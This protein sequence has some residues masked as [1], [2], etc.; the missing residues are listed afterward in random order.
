LSWLSKAYRKIHF[1][2]HTPPSVEA[3]GS[4]FKAEEFVEK[5][6]RA[7]CQA[8]NF[9]AKDVFG[10]CYWDTR[11]GRKHPYLLDRDL[12]GE[13]VEA[14]SRKGLKVIAYY[15]VT[16]L[17]NARDHPDWRH[18]GSPV[19]R[20]S[21]GYYVCFNS[22][23]LDKVFLP[24]LREIA[25][26]DVAGV[27]FDFLYVRQPCFCS[28]CRERYRAERGAE[29]PQAPSETGWMDYLEW[30]RDV[31]RRV[32]EQAC[33][34]LRS[35]KP[36]LLV[37][38][39]WAYTPRHPAAPP[40]HVSFL[41]LDIYEGDCPVLQASYHAKYFDQFG[42]PFDVMTTRFLNWWGD[43][44]FKSLDQ[45]LAECATIAANGGLCIIGDH[46]YV[47]GSLE[48][49][50]I[51]L[52]SKAFSFIKTR[53]K[54]LPSE[55]VPNIAVLWSLHNAGKQPAVLVDDKPLRGAH[56]MLLELG[57][58]FDLV[59]EKRLEERLGEYRLVVLPS[60]RWLPGRLVDK[61]RSYVREGGSIIA[62]FDTSLGD[63]EGFALEDVL[64]VRFEGFARFKIGYLK[65]D[66][67]APGLPPVFVKGGF[68][69]VKAVEAEVLAGLLKP[70]VPP[71]TDLPQY[72]E[73][74]GAGYGS[75]AEPYGPAITLNRYGKGCAAYVSTDVFR[76]YHGYG[77]W[78]IREL[79][80][81]LIQL[82]APDRLIRVEAPFS[83]EVT[84]RRSGKDY[85][86]H[87]VNWQTGR[88]YGTPLFSDGI[89]PVNGIKAEIRLPKPPGK[90]ELYPR[91]AGRVSWFYDEGVL[92]IVVDCLRIHA[93][94]RI[95]L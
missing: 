92:S 83:V 39:N 84:L 89:V 55:S 79:L 62:T 15:N 2:Y 40:E 93:V 6:S 53:E 35:V 10:N 11:V 48:E 50:S 58:H 72:G 12:L 5:L 17:L 54:L 49:A 43:W 37:G 41:T 51:Q 87:L 24:E 47:D 60:Q 74:L 18:R 56:K 71:K 28:W 75:P 57:E 61:L 9:F 95:G 66:G 82:V 52:F 42:K 4:R 77:G 73:W 34:T 65:P 13:V 80:K 33:S 44:G 8:F 59:C 86:L 45:V 36:E 32:V 21:E 14:A 70:Y 81:R 31:E 29:I 19:L 20:G 22:P 63:G 88:S 26:Y 1:D 78:M 76:G 27:F 23:W 25:R 7:G 3:V 85:F 94:V 30:L 16:D 64:G 38:I 67:L 90:V 91:D 46:L 69:R 68:A